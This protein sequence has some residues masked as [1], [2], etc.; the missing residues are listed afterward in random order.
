M[1]HQLEVHLLHLQ[2]ALRLLGAPYLEQLLKHHPDPPHPLPQWN[3]TGRRKRRQ[4]LAREA[5]PLLGLSALPLLSLVSPHPL[6]LYVPPLLSLVW[7]PLLW[8]HVPPLL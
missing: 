5:W 7:P 2:G 1:Q 3:P 8:L 6:W 4:M